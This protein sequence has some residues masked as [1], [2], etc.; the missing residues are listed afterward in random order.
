MVMNPELRAA[1]GKRAGLSAGLLGILCVLGELCFLLPDLLVS[2][3][4]MPVY[5][6]NI[7]ILRGILGASIAAAIALGALGLLLSRPNRRALGGIALG[8]TALLMGGP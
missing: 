3:D 1:I 6:A 2:R 4:A 7:G 5:A 8:A